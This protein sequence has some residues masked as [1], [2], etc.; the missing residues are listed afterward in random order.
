L[1]KSNLLTK[2][3]IF[4]NKA[5]RKVI[6]I[7][8]LTFYFITPTIMKKSTA[9]TPIPDNEKERL[10]ALLNY[11]VLDTLSEEEYDNIT[12][13]ASYICKVPISL[14]SLVDEKRQWF[15][16]SVGLDASETPRNISFC[17]HAI[18]SDD[19]FEV[20]N[21]LE[22]ETFKNNPLVTGAPDIRFYAGVPLTTPE[23]F[24][25]GTLCVIDVVPR[26]LD[27]DQKIILSALAK[28]VI[29]QL[30][31]KNKNSELEKEKN[32]L[33]QFFNLSSD[34]HCIL[35]K[36]GYFERLNP[37]ISDGLGYTEEE[38]CSEPFINF[39]HPEDIENTL[40][41]VDKIKSGLT[42]INFENRY[43]CKNGSY[44]FLSWNAYL[45]V[46]TGVLYAVAKDITNSKVQADKINQLL[47]TNAAIFN[48]T[49]YSTIYTDPDGIIKSINKASLNLL[50]YTEDEVVNK[51]TPGPFHDINEVVKRAEIISNELG[52]I[53]EPG[54]DTFVAK[55]RELDC[56]DGN[57]WTYISKSGKRIPVWLSVTC[58]KG[59]DGEIIGYLGVAEDY[60]T[61]KQAELDL[62]YAKDLA[63]QAVYAKDSFLA[64]MSHEIRTP[65][66]A[67]I[68]FTEILA[69]SNLETK[70]KDFVK[71]IQ[72]AGNNLLF[73]INDILDLSKL[74]S[75][76]LVIVLQPFN[77]KNTLK[78][79]YDLLKIKATEKNV[80][81]NLFLD[82]DMP[83]YVIGDNGRINQVLMNI[84]GN[85]LKFTSEGD[86]TIS[87]KKTADTDKNVTLKFTIK[88]TGIGI[89][90]NKLNTIFDR[91]TQADDNTTRKYG[92]TGLGLNIS[93]QLIEKMGG[94]IELKSTEGIGSEFYFSIDFEKTDAIDTQSNSKDLVY[95]NTK[96]HV[97]ILLCE[98]NELNQR[99]AENVIESFG[100]ELDIAE[101][102]KLGIDMLLK[103]QY[104][105]VI[106][107][108]Q[109]PVM[110]GYQATKHIREELKSNIP[111][112]AMTAH[113]LIGEQEKC[114][115]IGMNS[116][117]AKP[118][119]QEDLYNEII[120]VLESNNG[121]EDSNQIKI[122]KDIDLSYLKEFACS[123][124]DFE[125][126]MIQI[127]VNN[128]PK[129]LELLAK[130]LNDRDYKNMEEMSHKIKSSLSLF[131][132][133]EQV[134]Y[135][136]MFEQE[137]RANSINIETI[138]KFEVFEKELKTT[139]NSLGKILLEDYK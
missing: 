49:N 109:M 2:N 31:L 38:L 17:Q 16:S 64:N 59:N 130:A 105:L 11:N 113:S 94:K 87:V 19:V 61:K 6:F 12:K 70:Q 78:H 30:E 108:L 110:D 114:F 32:K 126:D 97:K 3:V 136:D 34:Y 118:F 83:D 73:I 84:A 93:K 28:H 52:Y 67:I 116:Y 101:N 82:A 25:I 127:F 48:G 39:V 98:D 123:N 75:G 91:F 69:K 37:A 51:M 99:L 95:K 5:K 33:T 7:Y 139:I 115:E 21:A 35:N 138:N 53:V 79:V 100:F 103:N 121:S 131:S 15:K 85:A 42:T 132:L 26:E 18:M 20:P 124:K 60:T 96:G 104:D 74:E 46:E 90:E 133:E 111:I 50:E 58:I 14:I 117:V 102:G 137:S 10:D 112:I 1:Y 40:N 9:I 65:M 24:N 22:N 66:N 4:E 8:A 122:E 92:G 68:G 119:K 72:T 29:T 55:A 134:N 76:K 36:A 56:P 54:F 106:M 43:K 47:F 129:D 62:I 80:D 44:K 107:D 71:N 41:E 86:V 45:D 89:P 120:S 57:E 13:L 135:L 63:E 88:D 27:E 128:V 23:G 125:K 81:F 77:L